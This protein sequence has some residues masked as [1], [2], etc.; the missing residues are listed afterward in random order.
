MTH[1]STVVVVNTQQKSVGVAFLLTFF[2]GALG[3]FYSTVVGGLIMTFLMALF[4]VLGFVT[5]GVGWV[6][7]SLAWIVCI[8]W[9]CIAVSSGGKAPT[10]TTAHSGVNYPGG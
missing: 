9:G 6:L 5:L 3:L 1:S 2:F 7:F 10:V 4:L 8:I